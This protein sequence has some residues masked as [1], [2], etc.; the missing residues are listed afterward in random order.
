MNFNP[1]PP[2]DL[3]HFTALDIETSGLSAFHCGITCI[4]AINEKGEVFKEYA[5]RFN[6]SNYATPYDE[7]KL[8]RSFM[9]FL[10]GQT[11]TTLLTFN[12]KNFDIPFILSRMV[13]IQNSC[14]Q[15]YIDLKKY[16]HV[17][18]AET[19]TYHTKLHSYAEILGL[20][21][22]SG[23]GLEAIKQW[24]SGDYKGLVDY[25]EQD[26]RVTIEV[27]KKLLGLNK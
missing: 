26:V 7:F 25:C 27:Y 14:P 18:I 12:G 10:Y 5:P 17:D 3:K 1:H 21:S 6:Y 19:T 16:S 9:R 11:F 2:K 8:I 13:E 15:E 24:K 20:P 23:T 4:V 22:K